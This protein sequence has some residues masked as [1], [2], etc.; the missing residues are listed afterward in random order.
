MVLL[1]VPPLKGKIKLKRY[2]DFRFS[3]HKVLFK[4]MLT[5]MR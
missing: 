5:E 2:I 4:W 1:R 3:P